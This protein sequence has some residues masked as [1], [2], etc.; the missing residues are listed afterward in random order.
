MPDGRDVLNEAPEEYREE[1]HLE[2]GEQVWI[3]VGARH[4][5]ATAADAPGPVRVL[6]LGF[7]KFDEDDI[8]RYDDEYGRA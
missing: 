6:E 5:L 3:P 4:R 1:R 8:V 7:G 2:P